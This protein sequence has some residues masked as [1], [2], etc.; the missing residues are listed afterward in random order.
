[1]T[2]EPRRLCSI[3][4]PTCDGL[5]CI[6]NE[7]QLPEMDIGEWII[8]RNMGA[9]TMAAASCFNGM[10]KP[11]CYYFL[12]EQDWYVRVIVSIILPLEV[13]E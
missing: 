6:V 11:K 9:Y 7:C 8:F 12:S 2:D 4:G 1:M 10:P 13:R 5:D 3:W